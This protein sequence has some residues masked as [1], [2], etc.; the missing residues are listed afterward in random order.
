MG[1][2]KTTTPHV[3]TRE[4]LQHKFNSVATELSGKAKQFQASTQKAVTGTIN[5]VSEALKSAYEEIDGVKVHTS[6]LI[7]GTLMILMTLNISCSSDSPELTA[8]KLAKA[9]ADLELRNERLDVELAEVKL[10]NAENNIE[11]QKIREE[12]AINQAVINELNKKAGK[13]N[14]NTP[15]GGDSFAGLKDYAIKHGA[16][17][18]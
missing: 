16:T 4:N 7:Y 17:A 12:K 8:R 6:K 11:D 5:S 15:K 9:T 18:K 2:E 10:D 14:P 3:N 1:T 13:T